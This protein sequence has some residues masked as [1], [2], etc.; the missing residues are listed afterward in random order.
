[1]TQ[2]F[3]AG[4]SPHDNAVAESFFRTFKKEEAYRREYTS[5]KDFRKS[6]DDFI[7]FYNETR[8]HMTLNYKTPTDFE[9]EYFEKAREV[10]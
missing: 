1:M 3:S 10:L 5:E 9:E 6:V 4:G 2:S 7:R 8:P